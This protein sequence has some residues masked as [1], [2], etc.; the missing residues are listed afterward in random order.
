MY[1]FSVSAYPLMKTRNGLTA[2]SAAATRAVALS[3]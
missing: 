2:A 1:R 3:K